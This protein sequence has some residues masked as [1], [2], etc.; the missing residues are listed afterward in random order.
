MEEYRD[1]LFGYF[2]LDVIQKPK[3]SR[4]NYE[5]MWEAGLTPIPIHVWGERRDYMKMLYRHSDLI[6]FPCK[7]HHREHPQVMNYTIDTKMK[8]AKGRKVHLLGIGNQSLIYHFRPYSCDSTTWLD[9][10]KYG[11]CYLYVGRGRLITMNIENRAA[12]ARDPKVMQCIEEAGFTRFRRAGETAAIQ[13]RIP[14]RNNTPK[15]YTCPGRPEPSSTKPRNCSYRSHRRSVLPPGG[16]SSSARSPFKPFF[17]ACASRRV[18]YCAY[19]QPDR[20]SP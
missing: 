14:C 3:A 20:T 5:K 15:P 9:G 11:L 1:R 8:W 12:R 13:A 10:V 2:A 7:R 4:R 19:A 6:G 16:E 18:E 17:F